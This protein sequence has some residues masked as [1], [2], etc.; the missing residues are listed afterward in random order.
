MKMYATGSH[1]LQ[2]TNGHQP[3][4]LM[5]TKET[6]IVGYRL[7]KIGFVFQKMCPKF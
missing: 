5:I 6:F 1:R 2:I 7:L 4:L 3:V